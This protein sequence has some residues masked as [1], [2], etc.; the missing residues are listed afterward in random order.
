[1]WVDF[2]VD[3]GGLGHR[4]R[5][6]RALLGEN[7]KEL[8]GDEGEDR[9]GEKRK[10]EGLVGCERERGGGGGGGEMGQLAR[11]IVNFAGVYERVE[12][13]KQQQ[14]MELERHRMEFV[15]ELELKRMK[16]FMEV[17]LEMERMKMKRRKKSSSRLGK[18]SRRLFGAASI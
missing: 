11:A 15:K 6:V 14:M 9:G 12:S 7:D 17:Q 4:S 16:M 13:A 3:L 2:R 18:G 10:W 5:L 8:D 1:M